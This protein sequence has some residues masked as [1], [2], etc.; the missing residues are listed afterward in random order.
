[1]AASLKLVQ[2]RQPSTVFLLFS[3]QWFISL[4]NDGE[5][6]DEFGGRLKE[7]VCLALMEAS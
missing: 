6:G 7:E 1:M 4:W 3:Q 5:E 2:A